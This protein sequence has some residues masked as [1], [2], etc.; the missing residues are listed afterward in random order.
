MFVAMSVVMTVWD[1][2]QILLFIPHPETISH[3]S[4]I[5]LGASLQRRRLCDI[6]DNS[7]KGIVL[8]ENISA[9]FQYKD[10]FS[11]YKDSHYKDKEVGSI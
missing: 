10:R 8:T 2:A 1:N 3:C 7:Y 11:L 9:Q 6:M 5:N 4:I